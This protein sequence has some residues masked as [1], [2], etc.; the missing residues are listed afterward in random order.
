MKKRILSSTGNISKASLGIF[1]CSRK[2]PWVT[3]SSGY[4]SHLGRKLWS[5]FQKKS[6]SC[7]VVSNSFDPM[8][9]SP[10]NSPGQ[11]TGVGSC[12]ILQGTFLT[13]GSNPG[14]PHCR[15]IL[16]HLNHQGSPR[17]LEWEAF[18]FASGSSQPRNQTGASCIAG[19]F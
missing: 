15:Q 6:E 5:K 14:L 4:L 7:S 16:Y 9:Y 13:L 17:I 3:S 8:D 10:W 11:N 1:F 2:V 18:P 12:S 19:G